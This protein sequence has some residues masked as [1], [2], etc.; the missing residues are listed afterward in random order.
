MSFGLI[1][2][3]PDSTQLKPLVKQAM[4]MLIETMSDSSVVV[5]VSTT[6]V[7]SIK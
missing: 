3:G 1:L 7:S 4:P 5:K 6:A 2:E